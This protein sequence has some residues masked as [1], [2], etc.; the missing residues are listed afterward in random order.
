MLDHCENDH[1]SEHGRKKTEADKSRP[2]VAPS[3]SSDQ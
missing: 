1:S 2:K 3:W